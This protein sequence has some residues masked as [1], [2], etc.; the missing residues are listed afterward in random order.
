MST[1]HRRCAGLGA[2][3]ALLLLGA[4]PASAVVSCSYSGAT[5]RVTV[6]MPDPDSYASVSRS[7]DVIQANFVACGAATVTNTDR[8]VINGSDGLQQASVYLSGGPFAPGFTAEGTG[9]SE[10]ELQWNGLAGT[11]S[12]AIQGGA[13]NDTI[14]LGTD[15]ASLNTDDDADLTILGNEG[16]YLYGSIGEDRLFANGGAGTGAPYPYSLQMYGGEGPDK[17]TGG[18]A[19]DYLN[20]EDGD[21]ELNGNSGNDQLFGNDDNDELLGSSGDDSLEGGLGDDNQYGGAG[22]DFFPTYT[23]D[24]PDRIHGGEGPNDSVTYSSR[25][26]AISVT[27]DDVANDGEV[28]AN[29]DDNVSPTVEAVSGGNGHD[30]LIGTP[31]NDQLSGGGG[32]D[33]ITGAAGND[34]ISGD[35]GNDTINGGSGGDNLSGGENNDTLNGE[36]DDDNLS[37]YDGADKLFGGDENDQ[38]YGGANGDTVRGNAGNDSMYA[39]GIFDGTDD[40]DGGAGVDG[41]S[42]SARVL[43][44]TASLDG[45]A[46]DGRTGSVEN[47]NIRPTVEGLQGGQG[48]D[49]LTGSNEANSIYGN[50]GNDDLLGLAGSDS[51]GGGLGDDILRGGDGLDNAY[52]DAGADTFRMI[53]GGRDYC[54]GGADTDDGT[55]DAID[56]K[57]SIP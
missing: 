16:A 22:G 55:F 3:I 39:E 35:D 33:T 30:T 52:G 46:N 42:Y 47:D 32:N 51:I 34:N 56:Y 7:G 13:G 23:L 4:A 5:H 8:I 12:L 44:V 45:V 18:T 11:D 6:S 15:A 29:E 28:A 48:D 50:N 21:D 17:L 20:G 36:G 14:R 1:F 27:R 38:L 53:D 57:D 31:I 37:G 43:P 54:Y 10:I 25:T 40:V 2:A 24:G 41:Y 9:V 26:A 19:A 49:D